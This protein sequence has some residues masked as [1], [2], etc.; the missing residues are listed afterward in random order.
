MTAA[1][2]AASGAA[3]PTGKIIRERERE[4]EREIEDERI[5]GC[6]TNSVFGRCGEIEQKEGRGQ[7]S[8]GSAAA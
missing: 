5:D 6:I 4:R 1:A 2:A 3:Q 7:V 8:V